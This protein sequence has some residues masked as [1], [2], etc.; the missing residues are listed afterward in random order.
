MRLIQLKF[1]QNKKSS[2]NQLNTFIT[3]IFLWYG[4]EPELA[5]GQDRE[6]TR[7]C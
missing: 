4:M 6:T 7:L 2:P 1:N 5:S 3:Y